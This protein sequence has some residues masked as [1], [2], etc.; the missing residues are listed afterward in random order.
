MLA[1][2]LTCPYPSLSAFKFMPESA[3]AKHVILLFL[4]F[5]LLLIIANRDAL[6]S[7]SE[8]VSSNKLQ[9]QVLTSK[10]TVVTRHSRGGD[11]LINQYN[12]SLKTP[13]GQKFIYILDDS[14]LRGLA[15]VNGEWLWF[16]QVHRDSGAYDYLID[17]PALEQ[18]L[19]YGPQLAP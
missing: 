5:A 6:F 10:L 12:L 9:A 15:P 3:T 13:T 7:I 18:R 1:N 16:I 14:L 2:M 19:I 17:R 8:I 4:A 11:Y